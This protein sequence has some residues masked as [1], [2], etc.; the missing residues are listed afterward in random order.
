MPAKLCQERNE[1]RPN[2]NLKPHVIRRQHQQLR[3]SLRNL[4]REG[5][6]HFTYVMS[7]PEAAE[8]TR[9]ERQPLWVNR[10]DEQ[11]PFD[12]IGDIHG[13]FDELVELLAKLGYEISTRSDGETVV[14]PPQGQKSDFRRGFC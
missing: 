11:G 10:T 8:S 4:K 13:C 6:R 1:T 7:T 9:V 3:H 14:Q 12:I 5:F 2:R